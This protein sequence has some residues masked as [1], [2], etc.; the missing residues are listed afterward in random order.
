MLALV[1]GACGTAEDA[2][3]DADGSALVDSSATLDVTHDSAAEPDTPDTY[4]PDT[5][6]PTPPKAGSVRLT[7]NDLPTHW[8]AGPEALWAGKWQ[9][10]F[11]AVPPDGWTIEVHVDHDGDW[12]PS[13]VPTVQW[14]TTA[15]ME[16]IASSAH[17]PEDWTSTD[18][19]HTWR[20]R[21]TSSKLTPGAL[22][23]GAAVQGVAA[24]PVNL[25][26]AALAS[27]VDPFETVDSWLL[28][29]SRDLVG[30]S[31]KKKDDGS[32]A[33]WTPEPWKPNGTSD[34]QDA[35]GALG[36]MGG[37]KAWTQALLAKLKRD[38]SAH[39]R[40][41][42]H[43]DPKTGAVGPDSVRIQFAFEGD[44]D[45]PA[46]L[47]GWSKMAIG[48]EDPTYDF[49]VPDAKFLF[50]QATVDPWNQKANNNTGKTR[51][52]FT[53]SFTRF[54]LGNPVLVALVK[55][56]AP[57]LGGTPYGANADELA[58]L[59]EGWDP[60]SL[61]KGPKQDR[62][63]VFSAVWKF[64]VLAIGAVTAHEIGHSLGLV[65]KGL[66]PYGLLA[67][68]TKGPGLVTA[69]DTYHID[70]AGFNLMQPGKSFS[71][72][73]LLTSQAKF[74]PANL[75]WLRRRL[76]VLKK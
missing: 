25:S 70:T 23:L 60:K 63:F 59:A 41:F 38:V 29:T 51:G 7:F 42:Y 64:L 69:V 22:V 48:G 45:V 46:D 68:A 1:C 13:E 20:T 39:L 40:A 5:F 35:L 3:Q 56:I 15:D 47:S 2:S 72:N 62:A 36:F 18:T 43:L 27:N 66:P 49:T 6:V 32:V 11:W 34:L 16:S 76:V 12:Q 58:W 55:D 33:V 50:G 28:T 26:V 9:P 4:T 14:A 74:N 17:T 54:V 44:S 75:A 61:P 37:G 71:A 57:V 52:V 8:L 10:F 65:M 31:V 19:G 21:I 73:D 30:I 24:V 67:G 53:T